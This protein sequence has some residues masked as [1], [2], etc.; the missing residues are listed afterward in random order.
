M[1]NDKCCAVLFS[2]PN[3]GVIIGAIIGGLATLGLVFFGVTYY[4]K[5]KNDQNLPI[6]KPKYEPVKF[7]AAPSPALKSPL[8][9][10]HRSPPN[11]GANTIIDEYAE[12]SASANTA[13][14]PDLPYQ[15]PAPVVSRTA[16]ATHNTPLISEQ[17]A[18]PQ[19]YETPRNR[20]S[21][22]RNSRP[23]SSI[24]PNSSVSNVSP[25]LIKL[26]DLPPGTRKM[27]VVHSHKSNQTDELEL[28]KNA[29]VYMVHAFDDG[30]ALGVDIVSGKQGAFPLVCC[31]FV[32]G[33]QE[34]NFISP[35]SPTQLND[36]IGR[37]M[38][39]MVVHDIVRTGHRAKVPFSLYLSELDTMGNLGDASTVVTNNK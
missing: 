39:S 20:A 12:R 33:E 16:S 18:S 5:K 14:Y 24:R 31:Q 4:R 32:D 3:W 19:M 11:S 8:N 28:K 34:S 10:M 21:H 17:N 27:K 2:G 36:N 38:S 30:W 25:G 35:S 22:F 1:A 9:E 7:V 23:E 15:P 26:E 37:R 29:T 13:T 6:L